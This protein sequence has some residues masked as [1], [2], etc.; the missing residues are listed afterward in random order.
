MP[1]GWFTVERPSM[2]RTKEVACITGVSPPL[3]LKPS[4]ACTLPKIFLLAEFHE[5]LAQ[6]DYCFQLLQIVTL[7]RGA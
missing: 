2:Y 4:V 5:M 1:P 7:T 6:A 3:A